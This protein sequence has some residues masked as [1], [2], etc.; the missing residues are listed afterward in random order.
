MTAPRGALCPVRRVAWLAIVVLSSFAALAC[1]NDDSSSNGGGSS[2]PMPT[3]TNAA[4]HLHGFACTQDAD[5]RYG[6]CELG[7]LTT[8]GAFG[9]CAKDCSCGPG[10]ECS[11]DAVAGETPE[12]TCIRPVRSTGHPVQC[13]PACQALADCQAIDSRYTACSR[14]PPD[15]AF[16]EI[17]VKR[18]CVVE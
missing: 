9:I 4:G 15:Y 17:G 16:G 1:D 7:A 10:S 14:T 6:R 2:C 13:V 5:C 18:F 11:A 12:F 3:V 8:G